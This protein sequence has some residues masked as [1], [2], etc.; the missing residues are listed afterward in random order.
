LTG[1][2]GHLRRERA[3]EPDDAYIF[4]NQAG[5]PVDPS[6]FRERVWGPTLQAAGVRFR[7]IKS[8]RHTFASLLIQERHNPVYISRMMGHHSP[9][10]TLKTYCHLL[11]D[12]RQDGNRIE[13][14]LRGPAVAPNSAQQAAAPHNPHA[15]TPREITTPAAPRSTEQA[16]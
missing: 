1:A 16:A 2:S 11:R 14:A 6:N 7:P 8:L 9:A 12:S 13:A 3:A 5:G 10:F 15:L 4:R